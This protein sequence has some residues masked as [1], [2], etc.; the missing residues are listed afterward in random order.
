LNA[1]G[2]GEHENRCGEPVA[3]GHVKLLC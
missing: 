1:E 2:A 3:C